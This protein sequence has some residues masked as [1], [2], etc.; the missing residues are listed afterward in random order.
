MLFV[1]DG[2][3]ILNGGAGNDDLYGSVGDDTFVFDQE[4]GWDIVRDFNGGVNGGDV[5]DFSANSLISNYSQVLAAAY[6][7]NAN[8][9]IDLGDGNKITLV[10][11][12]MN[13][14]VEDDFKFA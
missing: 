7:V 14:L 8:T 10:S 12:D 5:L 3:D 13:L 2:N 11:T 1:E 6:Q 4:F 9:V